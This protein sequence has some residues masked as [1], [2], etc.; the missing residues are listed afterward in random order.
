MGPLEHTV[1]HKLQPY[2]DFGSCSVIA[3][4]FSVLL[5]DRRRNTLDRP[6]KIHYRVAG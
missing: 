1:S 6:R 2:L 3:L 4:A 5:L